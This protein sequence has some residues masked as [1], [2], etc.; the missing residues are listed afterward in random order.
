[1]EIYRTI[2]WPM[3]RE[4]SAPDGNTRTRE[5]ER[6]RERALAADCHIV[7]HSARVPVVC[8]FVRALPSERA[9]VTRIGN[10]LL[11]CLIMPSGLANRVDFLS[12]GER[13]FSL[14]VFSRHFFVS[15]CKGD[16]NFPLLSDFIV[17][18]YA[19]IRLE[20][21]RDISRTFFERDS[22]T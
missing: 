14:R 13:L 8:A 1:M 3:K 5:R 17:A 21:S 9:G 15:A 16:R 4:I 18:F 6:E 10:A 20:H 7:G 19:S 2:Q 12:V 11:V 22:H